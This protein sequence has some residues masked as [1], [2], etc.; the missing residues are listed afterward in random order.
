MTTVYLSPL[1]GAGSQFFD[2]NGV[3]LAGGLLYTY[4]AGTTTP[5][6]TY[7]TNAGTIANANPI[8]LNAFG[9]LDKIGR[10]HV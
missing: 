3:P 2:N 8:V 7:T 1:A 10:A 9:R 4:T 5:Q 6:T